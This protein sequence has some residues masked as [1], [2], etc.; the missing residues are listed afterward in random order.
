MRWTVMQ[1][2]PSLYRQ[3]EAIKKRGWV[4]IRFIS[5]II[6]LYKALGHLD[7]VM[8]DS[9]LSHAEQERA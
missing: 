2:V 6:I 1:A 5:Y 7:S 8:S 9:K 4:E 3:A